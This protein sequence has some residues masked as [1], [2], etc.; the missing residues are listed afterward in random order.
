[1]CVVQVFK[2]LFESELEGRVV[3]ISVVVGLVDLRFERG[4]LGKSYVGYI[5]VSAVSEQTR[6]EARNALRETV[7]MCANAHFLE[8]RTTT[9]ERSETYSS[10]AL[11][12]SIPRNHLT[13]KVLVRL[14]Q[15]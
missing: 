4:E 11:L 15:L 7:T 8:C 14:G 5:H 1:M 2:L 12:G 9:A 13:K 6:P 10:Q 3:F